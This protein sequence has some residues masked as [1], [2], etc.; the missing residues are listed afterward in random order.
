MSVRSVEYLFNGDWKE[1][2]MYWGGFANGHMLQPRSR[3]GLDFLIFF[4]FQCFLALA[5]VH[6]DGTFPD[7]Q[8][9]FV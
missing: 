7:F 6:R 9:L 1:L 5:S 3:S 4:F 8:M 2:R